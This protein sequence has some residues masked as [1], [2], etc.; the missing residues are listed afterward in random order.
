MVLCHGPCF[1][2]I[3]SKRRSAACGKR[4]NHCSTLTAISVD[5]IGSRIF[6]TRHG[7]A[8]KVW[9]KRLA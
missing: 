2:V 9:P 3:G 6:G 4:R 5:A 1:D 8:S 7:G